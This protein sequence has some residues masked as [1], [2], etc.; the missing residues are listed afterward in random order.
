MPM[1]DPGGGENW[2]CAQRGVESDPAMDPPSV[3]LAGVRLSDPP[4]LAQVFLRTKLF[5]DGWL[6]AT[7]QPPKAPSER[8][9]NGS[10]QAYTSYVPASAASG[11]MGAATADTANAPAITSLFRVLDS[12][13]LV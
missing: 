13:V 11:A 2:I 10:W 7:V 4:S 8:P 9:V 5:S 12:M 6:S 1:P 3:A